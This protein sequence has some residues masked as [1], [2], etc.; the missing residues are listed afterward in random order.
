MCLH[1]ILHYCT[2]NK[3]CFGANTSLF[4]T[5]SLIFLYH[6]P[7]FNSLAFSFS[8]II[9]VPF[10]SLHLSFSFTTNLISVSHSPSLLCSPLI[11]FSFFFHPIPPPSP[12]VSSYSFFILPFLLPHFFLSPPSNYLNQNTISFFTIH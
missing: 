2:H 11:S 12:F 7:F 8:Y 4:I 1:L 6:S 10:S 5:P 3:Y 9:P